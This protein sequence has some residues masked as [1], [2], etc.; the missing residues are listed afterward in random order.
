[1]VITKKK[2]VVYGTTGFRNPKSQTFL[3][4]PEQFQAFYLQK[5]YLNNNQRAL[6]LAPTDQQFLAFY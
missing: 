3:K 2:P 1:M 6:L 4:M 5:L